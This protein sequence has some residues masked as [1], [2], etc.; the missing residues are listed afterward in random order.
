M[1][2]FAETLLR[3][4]GA[5]CHERG[6]QRALALHLR[7]EVRRDGL[8]PVNQTT[9]LQIEWRARDI[10]PWDRGLLSPAQRAAAFVEQSLV[11]TEAA[12]YRLFGALPYVDVIILRVLDRTDDTVII[13]G[14]V[15]R[16]A[17]SARDEKLSIG[18]R[19]RYLGLTY[20]SAGSQ[21]EPLGEDRSIPSANLRGVTPFSNGRTPCQCHVSQ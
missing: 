3:K 14:S 12:I 10:H 15:S 19:L 9:Q 20:H 7:G 8:V 2:Q 6:I 21:F 13:S 5:H 4:L 11:D 17:A 1:L 16:L 18:M